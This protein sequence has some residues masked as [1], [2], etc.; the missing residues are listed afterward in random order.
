MY[1]GTLILL[2]CLHSREF[3][4]DPDFSEDKQRS[5]VNMHLYCET[6][7]RVHETLLTTLTVGPQDAAY[8]SIN[9]PRREIPDPW[10]T[11]PL[12]PHPSHAGRGHATMWAYLSVV[13]NKLTEDRLTCLHLVSFDR[14]RTS[15]VPWKT[16]FGAR[17]QSPGHLWSCT[18]M[19][20]RYRGHRPVLHTGTRFCVQ[21]YTRACS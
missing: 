15:R 19:S 5:P 2:L 14:R 21:M 12:V 20:F 8:Y 16:S 1:R 6:V 7:V 18:R 10:R 4:G 17:S 3:L 13:T 9:N 11:W